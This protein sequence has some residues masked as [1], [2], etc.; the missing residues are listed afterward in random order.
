MLNQVELSSSARKTSLSKRKHKKLIHMWLWILFTLYQFYIV[1]TKT[2]WF[3]FEAN[4][5]SFGQI[6]RW[7]LGRDHLVFI[8][9]MLPHPVQKMVELLERNILS[10]SSVYCVSSFCTSPPFDEDYLY[11]CK[12]L[13]KEFFFPLPGSLSSNPQPIMTFF[14]CI[15]KF[16]LHV[17][18]DP[19]LGHRSWCFMTMWFC[20]KYFSSPTLS[21]F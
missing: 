6:F 2:F 19:S 17:I 7:L 16:F 15:E 9:A 8:S 21:R 12:R 14:P 18:F 5:L 13:S 20:C 1:H 10:T 4:K 11:C 3:C